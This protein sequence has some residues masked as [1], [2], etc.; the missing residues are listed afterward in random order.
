MDETYQTY[1]NRVARLSLPASYQSQ[2]QHIQESPKFNHLP[3]G[4]FQA[5]SFPGYSV[6]TPPW[7][8]ETGNSDFYTSLQE[9]QRQLYE[10]LQPDLIVAV[11][12]DSFH[13][14]L[15]DL[16]WDNAYRDA[17]RENPEFE[18]QLKQRIQESFQKY[19]QAVR[20]RY[21]IC[22]HLLG[23]MI[24]PRAI[25]VCLVPKDELSY[26]R[27]LELRRAIYQNSGLIALG[28]EQQYHFTAHITL[29]YFGEISADLDRDRLANTLL[30]LNQHA[31]PQDVIPLE[32]HQAQLRKFDDMLRYY[33]EPDWPVLEL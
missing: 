30:T 11:P 29:A 16:I 13:L 10:Q 26:Q 21:P 23:L 3:D 31:L 5:A 32:V 1:L 25:A 4:S 2:L 28:V 18:Q 9:L 27:T 19:Q 20:G 14:T 12:P 24:R 7:E 33:R 8:E 6:V 15:A 17:K 22:W